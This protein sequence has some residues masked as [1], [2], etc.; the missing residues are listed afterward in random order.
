MTPGWGAGVDPG[1]PD[2]KPPRE[3]C[4]KGRTGRPC[5]SKGLSAGEEESDP[6]DRGGV[7]LAHFS[8]VRGGVL[9][10]MRHL[11]KWV[12][13]SP[14]P[15]REKRVSKKLLSQQVLSAPRGFRPMLLSYR[16]KDPLLI[17]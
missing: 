14:D 15:F 16:K 7:V 9:V 2:Y 10:C 13:K 8:V 3:P 6:S 4:P 5:P 12:L 11:N 17:S 1:G